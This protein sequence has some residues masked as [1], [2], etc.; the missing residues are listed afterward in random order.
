MIELINARA[1]FDLCIQSRNAYLEL[2]SACKTLAKQLGAVEI[3][4]NHFNGFARRI[5]LAHKLPKEEKWEKWAH[6]VMSVNRLMNELERG[7]Q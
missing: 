6:W 2:N 5:V 3:R 7:G 1:Y 4:S